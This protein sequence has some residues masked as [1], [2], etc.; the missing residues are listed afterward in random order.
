MTT[1]TAGHGCFQIH[2]WGD[3]TTLL[4]I[5]HLGTSANAIGVGIG[6]NPQLSNADPDYTFTYNATS[7]VARTFY[8]FVRPALRSTGAAL[9]SVDLTVAAGATLDLGGSTQAVHSVTGAGTVSNGLFA[10]GTVLSPA[11]DGAVG[12]IALSG[13]T[14]A[15]GV[16]Y[17]VDLGDRLD[18]TGSLDVTG[19]ILHINNPEALVRSQTYTL[20]QTSGGITGTATLDTPLPSGWKVVR[21]GNALLLF[22]EGG[23]RMLLK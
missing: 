16:Q 11:G 3:K 2:N 1:N 19:L 17:R 4:S 5:S 20:I 10:A 8:V 14:L 21:R 7:Y 6:N 18:V 15:P 13:V 9:A 23:T 12:T 22:S